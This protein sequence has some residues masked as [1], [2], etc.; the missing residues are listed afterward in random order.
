[1]APSSTFLTRSKFHVVVGA[2]MIFHPP[3]VA[4]RAKHYRLLFTMTK[5]RFLLF[6]SPISIQVKPLPMRPT[7]APPLRGPLATS[8]VRLT[9]YLFYIHRGDAA[10]DQID[11]DVRDARA[12]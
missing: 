12:Y 9:T 5:F 11:I 7:P 8:R 4:Q 3:D 6:S 10:R 2:V 1:M